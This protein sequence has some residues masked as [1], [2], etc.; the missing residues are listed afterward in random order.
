ME[1]PTFFKLATGGLAYAMAPA[2]EI[3]TF[4]IRGQWCITRTE[5][6]EWIGAQLRG[7]DGGND[8]E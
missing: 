6:D 2:G 7:D 8:G 3:P 4:K 5:N 1:F